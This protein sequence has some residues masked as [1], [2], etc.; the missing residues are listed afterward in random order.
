M[1][2]TVAQCEGQL[3]SR[4]LPSR[5]AAFIML[6]AVV[7]VFAR[8]VYNGCGCCLLSTLSDGPFD[9]AAYFPPSCWCF[10]KIDAVVCHVLSSCV[11][12]L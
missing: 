9:F 7:R 2:A 12:P 10:L 5:R 3:W 4:L 11:T 6:F 1:F 8:L